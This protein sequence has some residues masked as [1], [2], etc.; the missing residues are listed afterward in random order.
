MT[1]RK[2]KTADDIDDDL[3]LR[4]SRQEKEIIELKQEV[5]R[6]KRQRTQDNATIASLMEDNT[7]LKDEI[8]IANVFVGAFRDADFPNK[9]F[10]N[11]IDLLRV[12]RGAS[13]LSHRQINQAMD[14]MQHLVMGKR[15]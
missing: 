10:N 9:D 14:V 12:A 11:A 5:S 1:G 7:S 4:V 13:E 3:C 8:R 6:Y 2:A 15:K